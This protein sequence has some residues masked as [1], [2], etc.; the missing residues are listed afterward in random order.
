MTADIGGMRFDPN[1]DLDE[2]ARNIAQ[3]CARKRAE[4]GTQQRLAIEHNP[5]GSVA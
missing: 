1:G 3:H 4:A 2:R 5:R